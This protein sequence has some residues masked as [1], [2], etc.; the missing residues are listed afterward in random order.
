M[1]AKI[2]TVIILPKTELEFKNKKPDIDP[3]KDT[4][5][6]VLT[7]PRVHNSCFL[8]LIDSL[9]RPITDPKSKEI[10]NLTNNDNPIN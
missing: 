1:A 7:P 4:R 9:S 5:A 10:I 8:F 3:K 2:K 6:K